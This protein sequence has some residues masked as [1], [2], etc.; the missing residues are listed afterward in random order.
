MSFDS[1]I[2]Y[3]QA[4]YVIRHNNIQTRHSGMDA[5]IQCHGW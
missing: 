4:N 3:F 5:R 1:K 2:E